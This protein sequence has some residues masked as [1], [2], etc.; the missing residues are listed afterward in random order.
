MP[1]DAW[2][3]TPFGDPRRCVGKAQKRPA[4]CGHRHQVAPTGE[5]G[6]SFGSAG[7]TRNSCMRRCAAIGDATRGPRQLFA[8]P[9]RGLGVMR[10]G[11]KG[12][13][14]A[15]QP[16]CARPCSLGGRIVSAPPRVV[17]SRGHTRCRVDSAASVITLWLGDTPD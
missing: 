12:A 2:I 3:G 14:M 15:A 8:K 17:Q 10:L 1:V 5:A 9:G 13:A 6:G 4:R 11:R 16:C 7:L